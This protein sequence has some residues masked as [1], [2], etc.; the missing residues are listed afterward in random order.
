MRIVPDTNIFVSALI[1]GDGYPGQLLAAVKRERIT[2]VTSVYQIDE[3][4]EVL[5]RERLKPYIR[6][7]ESE[8]LLYHLE[9]VGMTMSRLP[10]VSLSPD[11]KDNPI[12]ATAVAGEADLLV[13]GDKGDML[14]LGHVE[15]IPIVTARDAVGRLRS[16]EAYG[17]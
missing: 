14:A 16:R 11:P 6:P 1:S 15:G 10:E 7:E 17:V 4:R 2:L 13:S 9:A 3:L 5:G 12:L 8:D